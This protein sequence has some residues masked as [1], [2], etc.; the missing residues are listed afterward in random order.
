MNALKKKKQKSPL[1]FSLASQQ[2]ALENKPRTIHR[3]EQLEPSSTWVLHKGDT[4]PSP[5]FSQLS[6]TAPL[7][8]PLWGRGEG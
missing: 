8:P 1:A 4:A 3:L 7:L 6:I 2:N 5:A